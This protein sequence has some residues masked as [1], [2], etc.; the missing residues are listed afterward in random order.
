MA[1]IGD[2]KIVAVLGARGM[3]GTDLSALLAEAG[4]DVAA[5][6]LPECDVT[7]PAHLEAALAGADCAVNCAAYTNV[8][9]AEDEPDLARA[10]NAVAVAEMGRIAARRGL[11]LVH[12][13]TDF[14]FDGESERPYVETDLPNPLG[15]YGATKLEGERALAA[16]GCRHAVVRVQWSYGRHGSNFVS[17]LLDRARTGAALKVVDDQ[18]GAPTWTLDSA[19]AILCLLRARAAGIF[20]FAAAGYASRFDVAR[21]VL[22]RLRLPN[23]LAPCSSAE[24]PA[25]ARR[26]S[27]SRFDT[28]RIRPLLDHPIRPWQDAMA[29]FLAGM[30]CALRSGPGAAR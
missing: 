10:V 24:F 16:C 23:A 3:L 13:S 22:D 25:R 7:N 2:R 4:F 9:R 17:K 14:V 19:R 12:V 27:S 15:V 5:S 30:S 6:D 18:V 20:H 28:A 21:F 8:D 29:E 11:Y 1:G 26:P